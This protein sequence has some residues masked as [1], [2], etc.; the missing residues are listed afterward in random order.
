MNKDVIACDI[1]GTH[2]RIG[3]FNSEIEAL[4]QETQSIQGLSYPEVMNHVKQTVSKYKNKYPVGAV[5]LSL[6]GHVDVGAGIVAYREVVQDEPSPKDWKYDKYN[7]V[8][9]IQTASG[10][11]AVIENDG[12]AA[13]YAEWVM[14]SA[15]DHSNVIE[16]VLGTYIG[17]GVVSNGVVVRR[18]TSGPLI[19]AIV[20][21]YGDGFEHLGSLPSGIGFQRASERI[22]GHKINGKDLFELAQQGDEKARQI[23]KEAG[24]WLGALVVSSI[25]IFDP[26]IVVLD[27]PVMHSAQFMM[28]EV[29]KVVAEYTVPGIGEPAKI[30]LGKFIDNAG[31]IGA[32]VIAQRKLKTVGN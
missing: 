9:E 12:N 22:Y 2:F 23:F 20:T 7:A 15:I 1:G 30:E 26:E 17:S 29:E 28:D 13:L 27:G 8:E 11:P 31:L 32:A 19:P 3:V 16:L 5:G 21:R 18:R 24:M 6:A 4:T 25:N 10:L 14:G